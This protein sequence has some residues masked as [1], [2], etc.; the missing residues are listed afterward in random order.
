MVTRVWGKADSFELVFSLS[1]AFWEAKVPAD[2][3]DGKYVVELFCIDDGGNTAY[4]TGILYL[5]KSADVKVRI[6]ADIVKLWFEVD[7][8]RIE[9]E[10][11][12]ELEMKSENEISLCEDVRILLL[13]D[14][15]KLTCTVDRG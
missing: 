1:G 15:I 8:M 3:D 2:M 4:W 5:N 13:D 10:P 14:W 9:I 12:L 6:A 11:E 7:H